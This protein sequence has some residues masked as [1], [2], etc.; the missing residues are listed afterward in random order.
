[1]FK[2]RIGNI[3]PEM[4]LGVLGIDFHYSSGQSFN[5][6]IV[7]PTFLA[8]SILLHISVLSSIG[9]LSSMMERSSCL[10]L[11]LCSG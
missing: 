1:M 5:F 2:S 7:H 11:L 8:Y 4:Y 6:F 10:S 9:K 3:F